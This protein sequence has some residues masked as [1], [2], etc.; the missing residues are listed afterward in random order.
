M[1]GV[2]FES[3]YQAI[4]HSSQEIEFGAIKFVSELPLRSV[5]DW[6]KAVIYDLWRYVD[7]EFC[8]LVQGDGFIV[9]PES[10][11]DEFLQ[12]DYIGAPWPLPT[13][14]Y[15]YR[16]PDGE[17]VRVGNGGTSLRS[18][19]LLTLPF[20]L[21]FAWRPYFGN[22]HEDGFLCCHNRRLL[23]HYGIRFAP[24]E[25]AKWFSR[26]I[27]IPENADVDKPFAFQLH[28]VHPGRNEEF[29]HLIHDERRNPNFIKPLPEKNIEI[30]WTL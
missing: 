26:E 7:T 16:T 29:R 10:W 22:T 20:E 14:N 8:I 11:R 6:S 30:T 23:Q 19:R 24:I 12:Y 4:K 17:I 1:T 13:D 28:D 3:H 5:S 2:D 27:D 25:V 9:N 18:R 15:S 21:E